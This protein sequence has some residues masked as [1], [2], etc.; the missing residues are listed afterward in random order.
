METCTELDNFLIDLEKALRHLIIEM[1]DPQPMS[2]Y[3]LLRLLSGPPWSLFNPDSLAQT[4]TLF[5]VHFTV[6]HCLYRIQESVWQ[7]DQRHLEISPLTITLHPAV[8]PHLTEGSPQGNHAESGAHTLQN[9]DVT[10]LA[11]T[12]P[13][14]EYYLNLANLQ[15]RP[16]EIERMLKRF[17]NRLWG[18][19]DKYGEAL[20]TLGCSETDS[21]EAIRSAYRRL[22]AIHH[23]DKGGQET[24]FIQIRQA[25]E[26]ILESIR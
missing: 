25:Y 8:A 23:P 3:T 12:D 16:D 6:F 22:A 13:L 11:G 4:N 14:K 20:A 7:S 5:S 19:S 2:E 15:T 9:N 1:P 21:P 17:W 18:R 10:P 26:V 24:Q